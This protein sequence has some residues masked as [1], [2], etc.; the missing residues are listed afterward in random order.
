MDHLVT[1]H[2]GFLLLTIST[3]VILLL[4]LGIFVVT[5]NPRLPVSW[6]FGALAFAVAVVYLSSIFGSKI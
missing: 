3:T 2:A 6:V 1:L 4:G 5:R